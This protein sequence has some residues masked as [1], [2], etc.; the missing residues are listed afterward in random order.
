MK[1]AAAGALTAG[2]TAGLLATGWQVT[3]P[4]PAAAV[5]RI[6]SGEVQTAGGDIEPYRIRLL[7]LASFPDLPTAVSTQLGQ[8]G[9]MIPQSFEAQQPENV[10][11]G[12][13]RS[14]GS[15]D[16]AAL[17]SANRSTTL[18][19]FFAGEFD[20]PV[21]LR[22]QPD[23]AWLGA[24]PGSSVFGSAW[25]I[26][27]KNAATLRASRQLHG[28][29]AFNHDGIEDARLERSSTVRY[30]DRGSWLALNLEN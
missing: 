21:A 2:L 18:Y 3:P 24:E 27:T 4:S 16:W 5:E 30:F 12:S 11:H 6:E 22:S 29:A 1:L 28:A 8:R 25:G 26:A 10:I 15:S 20:A 7:P 23:N 17:C 13:F 14:E 9:C 19:V